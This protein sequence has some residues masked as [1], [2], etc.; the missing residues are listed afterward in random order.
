MK[1]EGT[2]E[3]PTFSQFPILFWSIII[4][5]SSD[6]DK[7][8]YLGLNSISLYARLQLLEKQSFS[9]WE[10]AWVT[11]PRMFAFLRALPLR[12]LPRSLSFHA[13]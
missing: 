4:C 5:M 2:R 12:H 10:E 11:C 6:A 8:D 13:K 9:I 3:N 7:L 1:P